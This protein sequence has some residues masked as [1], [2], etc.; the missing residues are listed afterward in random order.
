MNL[1]RNKFGSLKVGSI[2]GYFPRRTK[3]RRTRWEELGSAKMREAPSEDCSFHELERLGNLGSSLSLYISLY[4]TIAY[5]TFSSSHN[6]AHPLS[7]L[8]S[9]L[10]DEAA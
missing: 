3:R 2:G 10:M 7:S 6:G 4:L 9:P 8:R 1:L 5:L